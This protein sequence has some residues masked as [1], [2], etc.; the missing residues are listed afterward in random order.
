MLSVAQ[1]EETQQDLSDCLRLSSRI[2][3][4]EPDGIV[5]Q[6][7]SVTKYTSKDF[8]CTQDFERH[9]QASLGDDINQALIQVNM[10]DILNVRKSTGVYN[11]MNEG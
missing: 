1:I 3:S 10:L 7:S 11:K 8:K 9:G 4:Q 2:I 6:L 5:H